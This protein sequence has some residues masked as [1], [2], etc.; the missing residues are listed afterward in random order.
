MGI[1]EMSPTVSFVRVQEAK[2]LQSDYHVLGSEV[3]VV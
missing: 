2:R 1:V 3:S